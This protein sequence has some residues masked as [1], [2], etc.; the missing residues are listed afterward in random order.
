MNDPVRYDDDANVPPPERETP[1][2]VDRDVKPENIAEVEPPDPFESELASISAETDRLVPSS[3][4]ASGQALRAYA[5]FQSEETARME[6]WL[7]RQLGPE[8]V[9]WLPVRRPKP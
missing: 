2:P 6:Q 7:T 3:P 4:A 1:S 5:D 8:Y 9:A